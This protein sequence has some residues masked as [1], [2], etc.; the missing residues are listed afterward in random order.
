MEI[1]YLK[2]PTF[3][4]SRSGSRLKYAIRGVE[5]QLHS[6]FTPTVEGGV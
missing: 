5:V 1:E 2:C 3:P 4:L 6:F